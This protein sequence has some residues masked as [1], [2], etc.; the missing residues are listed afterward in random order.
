MTKHPTSIRLSGPARDKLDKLTELYGSQTIAIEV[1]I[2]R[3]YHQEHDAMMDAEAVAI[4][5]LQKYQ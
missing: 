4:L 2:D 5:E 1:A 3:L